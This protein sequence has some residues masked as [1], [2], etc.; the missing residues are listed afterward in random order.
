M[1]TDKYYVASV[2]FGKD[3]LAMLLLILENLEK[4]P[5]NEVIFFD[6]GMEFQAIYNNRDKVVPILQKKEIKFTELHYDTSFEYN[7]C[8]KEVHKK[9]GTIQHGYSWCG[10]LTRWGTDRKKRTINKYYKSLNKE[11]VEYIG[12]AADEK[13]RI[14]RAKREGQILPLVD[15]G[16]T[17]KDAL[18]Y[19]RIK[20]FDWKENG[21]DLYDIMDR[22]SCWCCK[23]NN[24]KELRNMYHYLPE[25]WNKLKELQNKTS[26]PYKTYSKNKIKYGTIQELEERFQYEDSKNKRTGI[27]RL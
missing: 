4:Y 6:W 13:P 15:F 22:V 18:E 2:S 25:Y 23:N 27:D 11:I 21:I 24:L 14:E 26:F 10:G 8:E 12:I 16:M 3:S 5:L 1:D 17:E 9:N 19:C 7:F 20:G